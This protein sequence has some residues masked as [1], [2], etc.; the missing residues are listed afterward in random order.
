MFYTRGDGCVCNWAIF[1]SV[2]FELAP[3]GPP[4]KE[5]KK[6]Y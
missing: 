6:K 4:K 3:K 1:E 2:L 5:K